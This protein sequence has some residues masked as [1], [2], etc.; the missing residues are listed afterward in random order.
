MDIELEMILNEIA[1]GRAFDILIA[2][3]GMAAIFLGI[4]FLSWAWLR[5]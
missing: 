4:A 1:I 3:A 2:I 5:K